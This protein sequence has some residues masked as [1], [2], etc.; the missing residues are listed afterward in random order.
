MVGAEACPARVYDLLAE[1][2]PKA[3]LIEGY[4]ITECSP[5]VALNVPQAPVRG[6]IGQ[7]IP[8]LAYALVDA[9]SGEPVAE[10]A[11][12]MLLLRGPSIFGGYLGQAADPFVEHAGQKWYKTGDI[13]RRDASGVWSFVGRLK[14]FIKLGGEMISLPA[15][16][17]AL[18]E[19]YA[20][21]QDDGPILAVVATT[22]DH[23]ELVLFTT[24]EVDREAANAALK[25]AGLSSLYN[26][27]RVERVEAIPILGTGKTDYRALQQLLA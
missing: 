1:R 12:G 6:T 9:E 10:G 19:K 26:L 20:S 24:A 27:R 2:C 22:G 21:A 15:I 17:S 14:R 5:I 7:L 8:G 11:A 18:L 3:V 13:V 23:P 4:G 25:A 16:E